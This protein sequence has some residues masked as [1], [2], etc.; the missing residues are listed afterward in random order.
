[1]TVTVHIWD[2][3]H[4]SCQSPRYGRNVALHKESV[5]FDEDIIVNLE[6]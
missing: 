1:M 2:S 4:F 5:T 3:G 6:Q